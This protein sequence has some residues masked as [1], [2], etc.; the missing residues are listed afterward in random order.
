MR[1]KIPEFAA[2]IDFDLP[3][4]L[5]L[6]PDRAGRGP[7]HFGAAPA[8]FSAW[9]TNGFTGAVDQGGSC[10]CSVLT[11]IPHCH[12]THTECVGHL[13]REP[14]EVIDLIPSGFVPALLLSVTAVRPGQTQ[15]S[16][17]PA[18]KNDDRLITSTSFAQAARRALLLLGNLPWPRALI[19]R[20]LPNS[21]SKRR[22]DY[23]ARP[24][25]FLTRE[26]AVWLVSNGF[27]HLVVDLPSLDRAHDDGHMS[28]H[29][30]FF[31]LPAHSAS[32]RKANRPQATLT[33]LAFIPNTLA[34]GLGWLLLQ[35][36]R[37]P[38]DAVPSRPM[39]YP[40]LAPKPAKKRAKRPT[41]TRGKP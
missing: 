25:P 4:D 10:N 11:L 29:R 8:G 7:R 26:A 12:G 31:G 16:T 19:V 30:I 24:A 22:R 23:A 13:T 9:R 27:E 41:P 39:F 38:G 28:A 32:K 17:I 6:G 36:A 20:T 34:E 2:L 5:S 37:L 33:E 18:A 35:A 14:L 40:A 21:I 3:F 15:E 1:S